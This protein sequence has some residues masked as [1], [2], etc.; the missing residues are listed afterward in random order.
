[1]PVVQIPK[2][3]IGDKVYLLRDV[4]NNPFSKPMGP[5]TI[6]TIRI[7]ITKSKT[8]VYYSFEYADKSPALLWTGPGRFYPEGWVADKL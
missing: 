4:H 3:E 8:T 6:G 7:S 2:Y 1:M 5:L